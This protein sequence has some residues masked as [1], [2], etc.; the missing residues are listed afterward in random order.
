MS[1]GLQVMG[2]GLRVA[3]YGLRVTS[4]GLRV[5]GY[6]LRIRSCSL[7]VL[8]VNLFFCM[9]LVHFAFCP[10]LIANCSRK[11]AGPTA[12]C[13][14][15]FAHCYLLLLPPTFIAAVFNFIPNLFPLFS[16]R[17]WPVANKADFLRK[18]LFFYLFAQVYFFL[19]NI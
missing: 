5:T 3:G 17:K 11:S 14:L 4:C 12:N 6:G 18:I 8:F 9:K 15:S 10:L 1:Y 13:Q 19:L 7:Q 16:P 2:Y